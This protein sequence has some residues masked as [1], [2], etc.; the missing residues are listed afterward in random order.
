MRITAL[1]QSRYIYKYIII[2]RDTKYRVHDTTKEKLQN[3]FLF[4]LSLLV[5]FTGVLSMLTPVP[6]RRSK[7]RNKNAQFGRLK[8]LDLFKNAQ[9]EQLYTKRNNLVQ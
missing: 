6:K 7:R 3:Q 2:G 9:G 4:L 5:F 1:K 8:R